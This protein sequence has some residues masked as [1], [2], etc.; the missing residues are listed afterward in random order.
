MG[1]P[2]LMG[3]KE[4]RKKERDRE[5]VEKEERGGE[6]EGGESKET[7]AR[8]WVGWRREKGTNQGRQAGSLHTWGERKKA[9][10][11]EDAVV[12][13]PSTC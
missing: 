4:K 9:R 6:S 8:L 12:V 3:C 10:S 13:D 7:G 5:R 1:V 2:R 11:E